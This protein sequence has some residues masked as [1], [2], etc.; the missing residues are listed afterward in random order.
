[1]FSTI[2]FFVNA[3]IASIEAF[4]VPWVIVETILSAVTDASLAS[5]PE[6][7][8]A[9]SI[10]ACV[11]CL[12]EISSPV[13]ASISPNLSRTDCC[14]VLDNAEFC[15]QAFITSAL[16]DLML[17]PDCANANTCSIL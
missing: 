6:F 1:M 3:S 10:L 13:V 17:S 2:C 12:V 16:Y 14:S 9:S 5:S 7:I 4:W 11:T 8:N 15:K